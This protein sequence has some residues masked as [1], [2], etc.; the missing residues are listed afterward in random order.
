MT[1]N[2]RRQD[3]PRI[4]AFSILFYG[5]PK[6]GKTAQASKF[7][8]PLFLNCESGTDFLAGIDVQDVESFNQFRT[9]AGQV[10]TGI[11]SG[12]LDYQTVVID[13]LTAMINEA[14]RDEADRLASKRYDARAAYKRISKQAVEALRPLINASI[15]I[16]ATGHARV[17]DA[18]DDQGDENRVEIRPDLNPALADDLVG[19]FDI[20]CY[21]VASDNGTSMMITKPFRNKA[22]KIHAGDRSGRLPK[23]MPLDAEKILDILRGTADDN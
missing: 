4:T 2:I 11:K 13:G 16:V 20:I 14:A 12:D 15:I 21:C 19:L 1:L 10:A 5:Q 22:C 9:L 8:T 17:D 3:K 6:V 23:R 18:D 7:P